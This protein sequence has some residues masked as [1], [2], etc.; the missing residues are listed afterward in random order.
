MQNEYENTFVGQWSSFILIDGVSELTKHDWTYIQT[1]M[2]I[3]DFYT[4][5]TYLTNKRKN[6]AKIHEE[7][8]KKYK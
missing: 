5:T 4:Y 8:L 1:Q 2:Y 6:E 7:T 3:I